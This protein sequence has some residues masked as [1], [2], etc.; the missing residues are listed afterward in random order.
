MGF[1]HNLDISRKKTKL[2]VFKHR[3][4]FILTFFDIMSKKRADHVGR[5]F[6]LVNRNVVFSYLQISEVLKVLI[7]SISKIRFKKLPRIK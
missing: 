2:K 4:L 7:A 5:I 6:V 1:S 3:N